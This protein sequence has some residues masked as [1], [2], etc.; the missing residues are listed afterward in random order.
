[1]R[2][3][4][5]GASGFIGGYMQKQMPS[6]TALTVRLEDTEGLKRFFQENQVE[7]VVHLAGQ[8]FIPEAIKDPKRTF[9]VNFMGTHHLLQALKETGFKGRFLYVSSGDVY[10]PVAE[11]PVDENRLPRPVNPY[12][13]SKVAAE[14]LCFQAWPFEIVLARPFNT[15]GPG[16][17]E[18]FAIAQFAK[19]VVENAASIELGDGEVTRD[20]T[21][22]RDVTR[23]FALLL[24]KGRD[25][26]IYNVCSGVERSLCSAV[27][28]MLALCQRKAPIVFTHEKIRQE[29]P[30]RVVGSRAKIKAHIGW[31]PLIPMSE[32][33]R[34]ILCE[35]KR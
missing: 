7:G 19:Q 3:V 11:L 12:G 17:K 4:I 14:A 35:R 34:D 15:I 33:L 18:M 9:E 22:V 31:E 25:R 32:T 28:E 8:S 5:T 16:Q 26:E 30:K 10:G 21:D 24:E 20:F 2:V 6:A 29:Q 1:M 27:E 23:A 13:V